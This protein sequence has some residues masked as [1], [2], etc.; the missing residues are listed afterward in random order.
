MLRAI[1]LG[2]IRDTGLP[3]NLAG[4]KSANKAARVIIHCQMVQMFFQFA[5]IH[6]RVDYSTR[7]P[8]IPAT[9]V[10]ISYYTLIA[11]ADQRNRHFYSHSYHSNSYSHEQLPNGATR[12]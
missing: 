11:V 9:Q 2:I 12:G 6:K 7:S 10:H 1:L 4:A 8:G 5:Y 3:Q